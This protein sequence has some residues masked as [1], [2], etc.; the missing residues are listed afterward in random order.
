MIDI[1]INQSNKI[2]ERRKK[3][4]SLFRVSLTALN[5]GALAL[6]F[7]PSEIA[8]MIQLTENSRVLYYIEPRVKAFLLTLG[9][10]WLILW[11]YNSLSYK[12]LVFSVQGVQ[13]AKVTDKLTALVTLIVVVAAISVHDLQPA[14]HVNG[15]FYVFASGI[16]AF[17]TV[18]YMTIRYLVTKWLHAKPHKFK[19]SIIESNEPAPYREAKGD[20]PISS[21]PLV[22]RPYMDPQYLK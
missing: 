11:G 16:V 12:R 1:L 6:V 3:Y 7:F 19:P 13:P 2:F 8:N 5:L 9:V 20:A 18:A 15:S 22:K 4:K 21:D 17:M 14:D 10:G